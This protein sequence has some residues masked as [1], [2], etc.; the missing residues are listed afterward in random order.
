MSQRPA[1]SPAPPAGRSIP[2]A[3]R[4]IIACGGMAV[5]LAAASVLAPAASATPPPP[6]PSVAPVPSPAARRRACALPA[7]GRRGD[8]GCNRCPVRRQHAFHLVA[9]IHAPGPPET[10]GRGR[11][12]TPGARTSGAN[13]RNRDKPRSSAATPGRQAPPGHVTEETTMRQYLMKAI[14]DDARRA[15]ERDRLY[16]EAQRAPAPRGPRRAPPLGQATGPPAV[17]PDNRL[18]Q[19]AHAPGGHMPAGS[20][21]LS[22]RHGA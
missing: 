19:Q 8:G 10:S 15:G 7:V 1:S 18:I 17:P 22:S 14:R 4:M 16:L 6:E 20:T 9:G 13:T 11:N 21:R 2:R 5:F 12:P 3:R